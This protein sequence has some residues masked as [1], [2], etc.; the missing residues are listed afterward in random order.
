MN[1]N[2]LSMKERGERRVW[3]AIVTKQGTLKKLSSLQLGQ[4]IIFT[5]AIR[6][7]PSVREWIDITC[8]KVYRKELKDYFV[9]DEVLLTKITESFLYLVSSIYVEAGWSSAHKTATRHRK[10]AAIQSKIMPGLSFEQVWR[11]LEVIIEAS[12]YFEVDKELTYKGNNPMWSMKY[13]CTLGEV[14]S[15]KLALESIDAFFPKPMLVKPVDWFFDG[16]VLVG[17]Y[18]HFQHSLVRTNSFE[19]DYNNFSPEVFKAVNYIQSVPWRVNKDLVRIVKEDLVHPKKEDYIKS[20]Y[21]DADSSR[22]DVDLS[23]ESKTTLSKEEISYIKSERI[24]FTEEAELFRAESGDYESALGKYRAVKLAVGIAE[25]YIDEEVIYFPHS[26]DFRGRIYPLSVGLSPQGSDHV[27]AMLEYYEGEELTE[28]GENWC[29]AYLSSLFGNDKIPFEERIEYGKT[30]ID[31]DYTQADEPYQFLAHQQEMKKFLLDRSYKVKARIHLDACNSG[32]QFTSAITGDRAGCIAT[33]VIPTILEDGSHVRQDAYILVA[34]KALEMT[35]AMAVLAEEKEEELVLR[36]IQGLLED[37]GRKICKTPVMVSNYGGT[38]G[39]RSEILWNMLRELGCERKWITKR[40][41]SLFSRIIGSSITGVLNGGKAFESYIQKMNN[42]IAK[43]NK[44]VI[45]VTA[46][47]FHVTHMKHGELKRKQVKCML[48]GSRRPTIINKKIYSDKM[49]AAKMKS[50]ISPNFIHSL[51]AELL[52]R[53][54]LKMESQ[55]IMYSDWIHDSFGCH[56][57]YVDI[58]LDI[59]KKEFKSLA[60]RQPL[61][62]LDEQLRAQADSSKQ[63]IKALD[64]IKLPRLRGFDVTNGGLDIVMESNWFFS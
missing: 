31:T 50:A 48:P 26:Y 30:L 18:E 46:D 60:R 40:N 58:M 45:W 41:A 55:G 32:S 6:I 14:I 7:L 34:E 59:T 4:Q 56:P 1:E 52:R 51:D 9:D 20:L 49:S 35:K 47:G 23:D 24:R 54:S 16:E 44:P 3:K 61:K 21:P 39:G 11:F 19:V 42:V 43:K 28:V 2:E 15:A 29:W 12:E 5:D 13:S 64:E 27:K 10:V 63:T 53:V 38:A 37:N 62:L 17:G 8:A 57:N 36:F 25:K 33:N 22:W